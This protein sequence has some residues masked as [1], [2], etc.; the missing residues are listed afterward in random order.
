VARLVRNLL[1]KIQTGFLYGSPK[2]D[3]A[4]TVPTKFQEILPLTNSFSSTV[5]KSGLPS[6]KNGVETTRKIKNNGRIVI[7]I[8]A[9]F[10]C[11]H[12]KKSRFYGSL[13]YLHA[14]Q[15]TFKTIY[16]AMILKEFMPA[17]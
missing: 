14:Q 9:G 11:A 13:F 1:P 2:S 15:H 10:S 7:K 3:F 17:H 16:N 5:K 8:M 4:Q 6:T 12:K